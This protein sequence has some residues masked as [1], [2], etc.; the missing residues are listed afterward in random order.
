MGKL[1][2]REKERKIPLFNHRD[3]ESTGLNRMP[4]AVLR[5]SRS[6]KERLLARL[7]VIYNFWM[8]QGAEY[9]CL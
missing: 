7:Y 3:L 8:D 6:N 2:E 5:S 4:Y 9:L 1:P